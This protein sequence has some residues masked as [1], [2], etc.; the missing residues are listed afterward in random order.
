MI[1]LREPDEALRTEADEVLENFQSL[2][3]TEENSRE[4]IEEKKSKENKKVS[5]DPATILKIQASYYLEKVVK[6]LILALTGLLNFA[7]NYVIFFVNAYFFY[8]FARESILA[9][10]SCVTFFILSMAFIKL[11]R[12]F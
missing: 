7:F 1:R 6:S 5:I 9:F 3:E 4:E 2:Y 11:I 12:S 10:I 8:S